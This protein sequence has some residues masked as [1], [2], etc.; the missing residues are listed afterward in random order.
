[1]VSLSVQG[2]PLIEMDQPLIDS[3]N[4]LEILGKKKEKKK[5]EGKIARE[6]LDRGCAVTFSRSFLNEETRRFH[7]PIASSETT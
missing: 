1:M 3:I 6:I 7:R 5:E 2:V 4:Q